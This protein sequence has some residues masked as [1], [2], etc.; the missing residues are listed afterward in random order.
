M[1]EVS[2]DVSSETEQVRVAAVPAY[3]VP[4]RLGEMVT[5]GAAPEGRR[6][7]EIENRKEKGRGGGDGNHPKQQPG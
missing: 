2:T 1:T 6:K 5:V 7:P 4:V 3:S